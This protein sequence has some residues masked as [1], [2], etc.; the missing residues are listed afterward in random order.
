VNLVIVS[1]KQKHESGIGTG[2]I[3]REITR[4]KQVSRCY[5]GKL[6]D[7]ANETRILEGA[8]GFGCSE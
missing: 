3:H 2:T 1:Y 5:Q 7:R 4:E 8:R 6:S